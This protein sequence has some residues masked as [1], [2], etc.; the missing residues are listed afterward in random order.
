MPRHHQ[1]PVIE[2]ERFHVGIGP[3]D[4]VPNPATTPRP[5]IRPTLAIVDPAAATDRDEPRID[6]DTRCLWLAKTVEQSGGTRGKKVIGGCT[7]AAPE[8]VPA[9]TSLAQDPTLRQDTAHSPPGK[10]GDRYVTCDVNRHRREPTTPAQ[11]K[12]RLHVLGMNQ[13]EALSERVVGHDLMLG[14]W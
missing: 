13:P 3:Y 10:M 12:H 14:G 8:E 2:R 6:S 7:S 5:P 1:C 9:R 4:H 11:P